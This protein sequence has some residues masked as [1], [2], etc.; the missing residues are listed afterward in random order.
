MPLPLYEANVSIVHFTGEEHVQLLSFS[1]VFFF[2]DIAPS[3][4]YNLNCLMNFSIVV[5]VQVGSLFKIVSNSVV[6]ID[7]VME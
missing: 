4:E 5:K 6:H 3:V 2:V 7:W 1:C